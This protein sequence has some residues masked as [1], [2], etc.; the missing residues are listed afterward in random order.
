M[1]VEVL[2]GQ[3]MQAGIWQWIEQHAKDLHLVYLNRP[4]IASKYIDF[5]Q[6]RTRLKVIYYGHD[7]HFLRER[8]EYEL[9]GDLTHKENSEYWKTVELSLM[10]K[11]DMSYYPSE[12]ECAA[13]R[14][15]DRGIRVKA[16]TAYLW[17]DFP[18]DAAG[19]EGK[20]KAPAGTEGTREMS[21]GAADFAK[22]EGLLFVGGF[23][24]P[25]NADAVLWF[26]KEIWPELRK[27]AGGGE[28]LTFSVVGSRA[29]EEILA[30]HDPEQG[31]IIRGFVSDEELEEGIRAAE[32]YFGAEAIYLEAQTYARRFYERH[33]FRPIS[34]EFLLDGIP[35][36]KMLLETVQR[37]ET[38]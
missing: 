4:H 29:P 13:I 30:L 22:R 28:K 21:A 17:E 18:G 26:L 3:E 8:R 11:A 12:T 38:E 14:R 24:H 36:V 6:S 27:A 23:A 7:L 31:V 1:G 33:G 2:Y 25:P 15:I 35:H 5:I 20:E 37:I 10:H 32:T 16:I 34:D 19:T 9:T